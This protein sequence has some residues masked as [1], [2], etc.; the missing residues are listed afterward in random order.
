M[1]FEKIHKKYIIAND[2]KVKQ[3]FEHGKFDI[4]ASLPDDGFSKSLILFGR[5]DV[6]NYLFDQ[7]SYY[8]QIISFARIKKI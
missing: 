3:Q 1:I 2:I 8:E 7:V 5:N 6:S 4:R